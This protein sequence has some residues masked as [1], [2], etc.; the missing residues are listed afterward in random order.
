MIAQKKSL[1]QYKRKDSFNWPK[2]A[3]NVLI[4][5]ETCNRFS[6]DQSFL[7]LHFAFSLILHRL[8]IIKFLQ[9]CLQ[10]KSTNTR[11]SVN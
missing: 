1:T 6:R 7:H 9:I 8:N 5:T 3:R 11:P 2:M 10:Q 4:G